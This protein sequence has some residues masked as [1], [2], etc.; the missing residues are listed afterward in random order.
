MKKYFEILAVLLF[1][2][3]LLQLIWVDNGSFK[4]AHYRW[5]FILS[6][7]L[8]YVLSKFEYNK[9]L[10]INFA[11][12]YGIMGVSVAGAYKYAKNSQINGEFLWDEL[13]ITLAAIG[14]L[15][16]IYFAFK[17]K[18][19]SIPSFLD[20]PHFLW[21]G[22]PSH[23]FCGHFAPTFFVVRYNTLCGQCYNTFYGFAL[24]NFVVL[25][26]SVYLNDK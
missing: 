22:R 19:I 20:I 26:P 14:V 10:F 11:I 1:I 23:A 25:P 6:V 18:K 17:Y 3:A 5:Y 4:W 2:P 16:T 12:I 7:L 15:Y 24:T 8:S 21:C 9:P 13:T